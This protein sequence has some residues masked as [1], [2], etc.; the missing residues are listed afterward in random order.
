MK[1]RNCIF[2]D[3]WEKVLA[4]IMSSEYFYIKHPFWKLWPVLKHLSSRFHTDST[5]RASRPWR[6]KHSVVDGTGHRS[7]ERN[8]GKDRRVLRLEKSQPVRLIS[9]NMSVRLILFFSKRFSN[10]ASPVI[11]TLALEVSSWE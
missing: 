11:T 6:S 10:R 3:M 5:S 8:S 4:Y 2:S 7:R 1:N 9:H